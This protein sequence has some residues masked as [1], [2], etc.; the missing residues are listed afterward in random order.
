MRNDRAHEGYLFF[1]LLSFV[2]QGATDCINAYIV[3]QWNPGQSNPE[4]FWDLPV[5]WCDP[6]G[7]PQIPSMCQYHI[8]ALREPWTA[9][10]AQIGDSA[11]G[12]AGTHDDVWGL[13]S[14]TPRAT[15]AVRAHAAL[16]ERG[17]CVGSRGAAHRGCAS[18]P[19]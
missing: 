6:G 17:A 8:F 19:S 15:R 7:S 9:G 2:G 3:Q 4:I 10:H 12:T 11:M 1:G 14:P 18:A 13:V 5:L 16:L